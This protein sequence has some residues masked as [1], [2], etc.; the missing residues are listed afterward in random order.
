MKMCIGHNCQG[1]KDERKSIL[2]CYVIVGQYIIIN[3]QHF[4]FS[5][6][7]PRRQH[8]GLVAPTSLPAYPVFLKHTHQLTYAHFCPAHL[9]KTSSNFYLQ[10]LAVQFFHDNFRSLFF[11]FY[12]IPINIEQQEAFLVFHIG[13]HYL[14]FSILYNLNAR[15]KRRGVLKIVHWNVF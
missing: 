6:F 3:G 7:M 2:K 11:F 4:G 8:I 12:F 5:L 13:I 9:E 1:F 15:Q 14:I 10:P